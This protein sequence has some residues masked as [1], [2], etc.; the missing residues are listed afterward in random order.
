MTLDPSTDVLTFEAVK[1]AMRQD[2]NGHV[3]VLSIHPN[4][5]P[6]ELFSD[7]LGSR[8]YV[9]LVKLNDDETPVPR[10]IES[11]HRKLVQQAGIL[12]REKPFQE[13]LRS[14]YLT[15]EADKP[16][17]EIEE[18]IFVKCLRQVIGVKSRAE[19]AENSDAQ[20]KFK[21]LVGEYN[22][23]FLNN[24]KNEGTSEGH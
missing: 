23:W 17:D 6:N 8:Y 3:L 1:V 24:Y 4:D 13:F 11:E 7:W 9:S 22:N 5:I 12:C 21:E 19:L 18:V 14:G 15:E 10:R 2:K 16:V 20:I